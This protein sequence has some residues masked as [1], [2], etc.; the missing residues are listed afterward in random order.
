[1]RAAEVFGIT[2]IARIPSH[3]DST[4]L[5]FLDR[6]VQGIIVPH[7]NTPE[8][9]EA[10][11]Q[12]GGARAGAPRHVFAQAHRRERRLDRVGGA[13]VLPMSGRVVEVG[14]GTCAFFPRNVPHAWKNSG[15][16]AGRVLLLYTPAAAGGYIEE[17][18]KR[19]AGPM[20]DDERNR[21]NERYRW[22]VVG[23]NPL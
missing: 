8:A 14:P 12:P 15:S 13:Q 20:S 3:E 18:W 5:R 2:P 7:I 22:E 21:L 11:A 23:P 4:I 16:E 19:P 17:L 1:M 6:G 9:A 10:V